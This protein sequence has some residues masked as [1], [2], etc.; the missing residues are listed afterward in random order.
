MSVYNLLNVSLEE[1]EEE[2]ITEEDATKDDIKDHN[3]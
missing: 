2:V 3:D 1:L